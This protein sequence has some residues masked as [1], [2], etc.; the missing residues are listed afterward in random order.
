M[1][2]AEVA[3]AYARRHGSHVAH[4]PGPE[5]ALGTPVRT[6]ATEDAVARRIAAMLISPSDLYE[7]VGSPVTAT[8]GRRAE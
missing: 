8:A 1:Q 6:A 4:H 2:A 5:C 7:Q 3:A